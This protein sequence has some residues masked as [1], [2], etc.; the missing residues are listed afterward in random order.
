MFRPPGMDV[1]T[2]FAFDAAEEA[3]RW[4]L[5]SNLFGLRSQVVARGWTGSPAGDQT[6]HLADKCD[7]PPEFILHKI[8][9]GQ[10]IRLLHRATANLKSLP[11]VS[12]RFMSTCQTRELTHIS[13][14]IISSRK[15]SKVSCVV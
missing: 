6:L 5:D 4:L 11:L 2:V 3:W 7:R 8:L 13:L 9:C 14:V 15:S 10:F 1:F 12:V